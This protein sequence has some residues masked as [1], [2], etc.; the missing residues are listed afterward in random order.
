MPLAK[1]RSGFVVHQISRDLQHP[2]LIR[3]R[4][5]STQGHSAS[6][7][8]D[9]EE[10]LLSRQALPTPH[11]NRMEVTGRNGFP[12]SLEKHRPRDA[13]AAGWR[14]LNQVIFQNATNRA[15]PH[16]DLQIEQRT[17]NSRVAPT[18]VLVGYPHNEL[19]GLHLRSRSSRPTALQEC[20]LLR[21][22]FTV[23]TQKS[24]RGHHRIQF[25]Q[26]GSRPSGIRSV[27]PPVA[28][29]NKPCSQ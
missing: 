29:A 25:S 9:H 7:Q 24:C 4:R 11:L 19:L 12:V 15:A 2:R 21:H 17:V 13:A 14:R 28:Q 16:F 5:D 8:L 22:Q 18:R 23:P 3:V 27:R 20:P 26:R 6:S 1:E 10:H